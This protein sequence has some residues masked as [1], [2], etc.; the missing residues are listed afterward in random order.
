MQLFGNSLESV[1]SGEFGVSVNVFAAFRGKRQ[2]A[3]VL[4]GVFLLKTGRAKGNSTARGQSVYPLLSQVPAADD[5]VLAVARV[6]FVFVSTA[7]CAGFAF[8]VETISLK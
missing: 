3:A 7:G 6:A 1:G 5:V 8:R 4:A 2:L